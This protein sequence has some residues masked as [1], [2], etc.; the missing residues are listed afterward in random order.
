MNC[1]PPLEKLVPEYVRRFQAYVPSKPDDEL[2]KLYGCSRLFRLNNNE[3][4]LGPSQAAREAI[5][6][7][8][9]VRSS[10]YPSGDAYHLRMKLADRFGMHPDQFLVGNGANEVISFVIKAFCQE[11]D[12]IITADKTFAVYEW[13]AEFSGFEARLVPLIDFSFDDAGMLDRIDE[14]TKILFICNPNNPTGTWWDEKRLRHFLN[15][16]AG[17]QIVVLDEAYTEFVESPDF[18]NGMALLQEYPNMV[19]FRTFSK[20]FALAGLRIGYLAGSME[21]VDIIRRTCVVYSVNSLA[22]AAACATL[23]DSEEHVL[24]TRELIRTEKAFLRRE[25]DSLGLRAVSG[26]GNFMM[27]RLPINDTLA[28]RKMMSRGVMV[29]SM[30]GF[31]FPNWIRVSIARHD[32]M[33]AFIEALHFIL[34]SGQQRVRQG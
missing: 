18:P 25:I 20:M 30:T 21:V 6:H 27:I 3:N 17:R 10:I 16:V 9:A 28:Y 14:R 4:A 22:Q 24:R 1:S 26:E 29:R 19:V 7:F 2:K 23:D 13:V 8:P 11:G 32:A 33:Q 34:S 5:R 31:R 15:R 12:N